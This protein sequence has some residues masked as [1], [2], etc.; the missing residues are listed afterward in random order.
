MVYNK[1]GDEF[2]PTKNYIYFQV[3]D[4]IAQS[5]QNWAD[6][7]TG[8]PSGA[9]A[10]TIEFSNSSWKEVGVLGAEVIRTETETIGNYKLGINTVARSPHSAYA[11]AFVDATTTDPRANLDVVGKAYISGK[12]LSTSPNN[13]LA[14]ATP[15]NRT[16]NAI[17]DAFVVGG[18]SLAATNYSTLR[19]DTNTVAI[20]EALEEII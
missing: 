10:P 13:Y 9:T 20:T 12:T 4:Q 3:V 11:N 7:I 8:T 14:N 19:V 15:S 2:S 16:F 5:T 1:P 6:I 17:A 18:D